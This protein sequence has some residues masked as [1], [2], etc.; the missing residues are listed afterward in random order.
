MRGYG[1][2]YDDQRYMNG[3]SRD[4]GD[5]MRHNPSWEDDAH[6]N[7]GYDRGAG[8]RGGQG[9]WGGD[10]EGRG[11]DRGLRRGYGRDYNDYGQGDYTHGDFSRQ[12]PMR[13]R[14]GFRGAAP[15]QGGFGADRGGM[16]PGGGFG[17]GVGS[18]RPGGSF[19]NPTTRG[20]FFRGYGG[21]IPRGYSPFW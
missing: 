12:Q 5:R 9:R 20:D 1:R 18:Y 6:G 21:G 15:D 13:N 16:G 8:Y 4:Y 17:Y 10:A 14:G 2:D 11:Y 3:G 7:R 19:S